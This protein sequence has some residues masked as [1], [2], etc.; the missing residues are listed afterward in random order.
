MFYDLIITDSL[1]KY[2]PPQKM[3]PSV[4]GRR[5]V[6]LQTDVQDQSERRVAAHK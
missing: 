1:Q 6:P 4:S 2:K 5:I 3:F